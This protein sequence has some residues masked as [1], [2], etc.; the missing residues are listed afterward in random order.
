MMLSG[1]KMVPNGAKM[2]PECFNEI[3]TINQKRIQR[4]EEKR[5]LNREVQ[6]KLCFFDAEEEEDEEEEEEEEEKRR[7]A[8]TQPGGPD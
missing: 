7:E 3:Y 1:A 8:K 6:T 2:V 5:R 4:R